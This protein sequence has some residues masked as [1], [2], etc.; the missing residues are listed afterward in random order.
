MKLFDYP[1]IK[2]IA[3]EMGN[4]VTP[5]QVLISWGYLGG[6]SGE[7]DRSTLML[8]FTDGHFR[9]KSFPSPS[10]LREFSRTSSP[11]PSAPITSRG[12]KRSEA[13][14]RSDSTSVRRLSLSLLQLMTDVPYALAINYKPQWFINVFNEPAERVSPVTVRA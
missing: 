1:E 12:S 11:S 14:S 2:A 3:A 4:G 8:I 10:P 6:H 7:I 9:K 5:A 13:P